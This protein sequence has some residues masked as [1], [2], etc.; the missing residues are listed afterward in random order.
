MRD[1]NCSTRVQGQHPLQVGGNLIGQIHGTHDDVLDGIGK[2]RL[3]GVGL[4]GGD[5]NQLQ[6]DMIIRPG[7]QRAQIPRLL[8]CR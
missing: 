3:L 8:R 4:G 5:M 1:G 6:I 7:Q 2:P